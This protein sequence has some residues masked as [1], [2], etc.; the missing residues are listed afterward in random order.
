M[1]SLRPEILIL[2]G[3]LLVLSGAML[4]WLIVLRVLEST[5]FLN[6]FSFTASVAGLFL[7]MIGSA[8][9]VREYRRKKK[10]R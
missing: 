5:L 8:T 6:F 7:G 9:Y 10:D 2:I 1:P 4:P 3:F